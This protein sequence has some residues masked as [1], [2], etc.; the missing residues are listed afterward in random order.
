MYSLSVFQNINGS[1]LGCQ[2][3]AVPVIFVTGTLNI[4][5]ERTSAW[6]LGSNLHFDVR[7]LCKQTPSSQL[8]TTSFTSP[9]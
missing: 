7:L 3:Y 9:L 5:W 1:V 4:T 2:A 6:P 8:C